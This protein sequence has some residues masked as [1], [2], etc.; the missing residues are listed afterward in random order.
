MTEKKVA[1]V[2]IGGNALIIDKNRKTIPDQFDAIKETMSH[3]AGMIE[4]GWD[5]V[6]THAFLG[7]FFI[8][9]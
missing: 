7:S 2:A 3:I 8:E 5:V 1:V 9:K 6:I 4:D